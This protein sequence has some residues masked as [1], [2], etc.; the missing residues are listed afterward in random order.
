[1]CLPVPSQRCFAAAV[2]LYDQGDFA[3]A[4]A[5]FEEALL[6]YF[7]ADVECRALCQWPQKFEGYDYLRYRYS[8]YEVVSGK[9]GEVLYCISKRAFSTNQGWRW[10]CVFTPH[11]K[12]GCLIDFKVKLSL[13]KR[14]KDVKSFCFSY[15][16][17]VISTAPT[18]GARAN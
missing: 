12:L 1:M 17:G 7:R 16:Q 3:A 11:P 5:E 14:S 8:L 6:E 13:S 9:T 2:K 10:R 4:I 18:A 15:N